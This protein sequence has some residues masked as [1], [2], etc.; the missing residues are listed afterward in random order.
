MD[1]QVEDLIRELGL[2]PHPEGGYYKE[3][4]RCKEQIDQP[5]L[6]ARFNGVRNFS[7]AIYYLLVDSDYSSF[8]RILSD[9]I[10]HHYLG[11]PLVLFQIDNE[12]NLQESILG[13]DIRAGQLPQ[14]VIPQGNWFAAKVLNNKGF[15]LAGCT[16]SPGFDFSDF[17][18]GNKIDLM[19]IFPLHAVIIE[20][21]CR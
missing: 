20:E 13:N 16:V 6:P 3:T 9:E 5:Q 4:Y 12:G 18:L 17:E 21:L 2:Q 10:W 7:T 15:S 8:H 11:S 19:E 14:L 1:L